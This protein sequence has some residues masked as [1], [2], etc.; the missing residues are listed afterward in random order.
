MG[1]FFLSFFPTPFPNEDI[2]SIFYRYHLGVFNSEIIDTNIEL[3]GIGNNFPTLPRSLNHLIRRLPET[4]GISVNSLIY[5]H[6]LIPALLPFTPAHH[7]CRLFNEMEN[8]GRWEE[9]S[10]GKLMGNKYARN[11]SE[12]IKYCPLC[13]EEDLVR[14]G[15]S[16]IHRDHQYGFIN[17]C[18]KHSVTLITHCSECD[19]LLG[20]SPLKEKCKNGHHNFYREQIVQLKGSSIQQRLIKDLEY[21]INQSRKI[22]RWVIELKFLEHLS[23]KGYISKINNSIFKKKLIMDFENYHSLDFSSE[24]GLDVRYRILETVF[25]G[26][27]LVVN[28]PLTLLFIQFLAGSIKEF[29]HDTSPYEC[30]LPFGT[31]PWCCENKFCLRYKQNVI[32]KCRRTF[33]SGLVKGRFVCSYCNTSYVLDWK[34]NGGLKTKQPKIEHNDIKKN[35]IISLWKSG[36][37]L[38][39]TSKK[40]Y[41][42]PYFVEKVVKQIYKGCYLNQVNAYKEIAA[43][44][45]ENKLKIIKKNHRKRLLEIID[46]NKAM[47]RSEIKKKCRTSYDWLQKHDSLWLEK[48]LPPPKTNRKLDK[49]KRFQQNKEKYRSRLID[50]LKEKDGL[51]RS[52]IVMKCKAACAWLKKHDLEWLEGQLPPAIKF[53]WNEVDQNLAQRVRTVSIQLVNSNPNIRVARYTIMGALTKKE[54]GRIKSYIQH[55]PQT[56]QALAECA[57]TNSTRFDIYQLWSSSLELI[58][59]IKRFHFIV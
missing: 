39:E 25:R 47:T 5:N 30:E 26:K 15:C 36:L 14:Y 53:D 13:I 20:Y 1:D 3:L 57:E 42:S 21:I 6:T 48:R 11:I 28:L 10:V 43:S 50:F 23:S 24:F 38:E 35:Q 29:L 22:S 44:T 56:N 46:K 2:R 59:I 45:N 37:S 40:L 33:H 54:R 51:K 32:K 12:I 18:S 41:C 52:E 8:G 55:L 58:I 9:S 34:L 7:H 16:Y 4:T 49:K 19:E 31:G 17:I 27:Q